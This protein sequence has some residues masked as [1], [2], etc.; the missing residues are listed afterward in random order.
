MQ[1]ADGLDLLDSKVA[2]VQAQWPESREDKLRA[3][4]EIGQLVAELRDWR[5]WNQHKLAKRADVDMGTVIRL[6]AGRELPRPGRL[7]VIAAVLR[8]GEWVPPEA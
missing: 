4:S 6:E 8:E 7:S 2:A 5:G 1:S 3:A